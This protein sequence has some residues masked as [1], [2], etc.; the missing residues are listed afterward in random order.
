MVQQR[1]RREFYPKDFKRATAML[2][3]WDTRACSPEYPSRMHKAVLNMAWGNYAKLKRAI[4][5]ARVDYRDVL[6]EGDDPETAHR[7]GLLCER[8]EG[9]GSPDEEAFLA[10]IRRKPAD[11][12][13]RLIYSDWLEERGDSQRAEYLRVLCQW[14]ACHPANDRRLIEREFELRK[15]LS[16]WW[17]A[18][19]RGIP[20]RE[21]RRRRKSTDEGHGRLDE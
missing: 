20:V 16:R 11:N 3:R 10:S 4:A 2:T 21:R 17:L 7:R 19:I 15:G 6:L 8:S 13:P 9:T 14:L 5:M 1:V 18:R 12:A